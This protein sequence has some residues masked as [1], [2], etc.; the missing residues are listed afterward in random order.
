[1]RSSASQGRLP[2]VPATL[3]EARQRAEHLRRAIEYHNYRYYVLDDPEL[4]DAAYDALI[5]ELRALEDAFPELRTP[6]SPTQRV[7][8]PPLDR[9]EK[10]HHE[11]PML[12]LGNAFHADEVRRWY[13]RVCRLANREAL[14]LVVE[15]KID[16]L[17]V[18]LLYEGGRLVR[19]A[20]RGDGLTG[21]D[22]TPNV[23]TVKQIPLVIPVPAPEQRRV[24]WM[25]PFPAVTE[26]PPRL[27]VRG[28]VYMRKSDF[29]AL[30]RRQA[31]RGERTFA[32]P[33]N[34]AAGSL[35]Q[36]DSR[37]TA[38]RPLSF[39]AYGVGIVEGVNVTTH[40]EL[41]GYLGALGFPI[42]PDAR[43]CTSLDE[44][45]VYAEAWL[46]R[47][48]ELDYEADG[49][50][51]KVNDLGMYEQ[52]GATGREPRWAIAYKAPPS[53][54]VTVLEDIVV[55][56]GRTGQVVPTAVLRP[57]EVGGVVVS[58]ATLHNADYI[59]E[60]DL[61]IGDHVI[62][63]RAGD[64]IPQVVRPLLELRTGAE[65]PWQMPNRCP[66]CGEPLVQPEGEVAY[67]CTNV[68]CPAQLIRRVE[69][70]ASRNAMDI[71]GFGSKLAARFVKL[72]LLKDPADLYFLTKEQILGVEGFAEKSAENLLRAIEESKG[73]GLARLLTALGIRYVG[74]T[75]AELLARHYASLD[76]IM[77]A[78][79]EELEAI[80]GI[81][82]RTAASFVEWFSRPQNRQMV[83]KLRRAGVRFERVGPADEEDHTPLAGLT[84][85]LTGTLPTM[86]REEAKALIQEH[87]GRVVSSVSRKTD[88]VVAG[89]RA[90]SKLRRAQELGIPVISEDDLR[91]MV[92]TRGR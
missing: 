21:E 15:P 49:V 53:E 25:P 87:G 1:M 48:H 3:E 4:S 76:E 44:A 6:D 26:P 51:F 45:L 24:E 47:R 84:F 30:N 7:G 8:A 36:L 37:I 83:E 71:E 92:I 79:L 59:Q 62:V 9:F 17:A 89:E 78:S 22:V 20:T 14:D 57:V 91:H 33:R 72:G 50:V 77:G 23:R 5:N 10:V 64:V 34:A 63:R 40:W 73:R 58:H 27:E 86:T 81:G 28:E 42:N 16:G 13:R 80:E 70:F 19:G 52:L 82:P 90:G 35:R 32:N 46:K 85:V 38:R 74:S 65:R 39:F 12:S 75:V 69:H 31:E 18:T 60:R 66:S 29:E 54:A 88:Y 68:A 2:G 61:R 11:V 55:N 41:L 56:V 67:Y 43:L